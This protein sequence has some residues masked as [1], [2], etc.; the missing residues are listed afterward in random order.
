MLGGALIGEADLVPA[1][2]AHGWL[3]VLAITSQ[4]VGWLLISAS[5]PRLPAAQTSLL[6]TLQPV[7]SVLLG[8]LIFAEAPSALQLVGVAADPR[9]PRRGRAG[10]A[11]RHRPPLPAPEHGRSKQPPLPP[12]RR[13]R[14]P[15]RGCG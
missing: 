14:C 8:V 15:W 3:V 12:R 5:L 4:V 2:P 1:W 6:L 7:G 11:V 10:G 9:R 13:A